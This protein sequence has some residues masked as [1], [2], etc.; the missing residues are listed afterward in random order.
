MSDRIFFQ[1]DGLPSEE[2]M[3]KRSH[4][5]CE[6]VG[7][8]HDLIKT[9]GWDGLREAAGSILR[10]EFA[11]QDGISWLAWGWTKSHEVKAAAAETLDGIPER[12][13][14][15]AGH[16]FSQEVDPTVTLTCGALKMELPFTLELSAEVKC[17]DLVVRHGC[18][19]A[20]EAASLTP[21]ATL[22]YKGI[23]I[24]RTTGNSIELPEYRLPGDGL[25]IGQRPQ[26]DD[27]PPA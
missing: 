6:E 4:A 20:L 22:S 3:K 12:K 25:H 8:T 27:N 11:K 13:V 18:L 2:A 23:E 24:S 26:G 21:S 16:T 14:K 15:L 19:V 5:I 1:I 17:I 9:V 7:E 10:E